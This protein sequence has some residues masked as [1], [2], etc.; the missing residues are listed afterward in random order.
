MAWNSRTYHILSDPQTTW[1]AAVLQRIPDGVH[2]RVIDLGCG[3]GRVTYKLLETLPSTCVI[4]NDCAPDMLSAAKA[5]LS[6][7][8]GERVSFCLGDMLELQFDEEF[9]GVFSSAAFHWVPDHDRLFRAVFR[10]LS[11]R[12]WLEAQCGGE[13]NLS[14]L[15]SRIDAFL[16]AHRGS[17]PPRSTGVHYEGA[18][19][20]VRR[21]RSA[22][23][24]SARAWTEDAPASFRDRH[25]F[26]SFIAEIY[27]RSALPWLSGSLRTGLANYL[28][29]RFGGDRLPYTLDY[30]RLNISASK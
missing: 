29:D 14:L 5:F 20:T 16:L 28:A 21:L 8:F 22:G 26:T 9:D 19:A 4:A 11:R 2:R 15:R 25:S 30:V 18:R 1:G 23:F 27:F 10:M 17:G 24:S 12:G 7:V 6:P 3:T 13:R